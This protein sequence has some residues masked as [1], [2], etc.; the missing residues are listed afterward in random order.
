MI[1][2]RLDKIKERLTKYFINTKINVLKIK[3]N[4]LKGKQ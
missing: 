4:Y 1:L 2:K 3:N